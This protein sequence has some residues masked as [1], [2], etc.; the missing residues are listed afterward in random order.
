MVAAHGARPAGVVPR[1]GARR[2]PAR[3][4]RSGTAGTPAARTARACSTV[5]VAGVLAVLVAQLVAPGAVA[6]AGVPLALIGIVLGVPHGAVDHM[7]P[8]WTSGR[9][10]DRAALARVLTGYL[11]VAAAAATALLVLPTVTV[12]VFLVVSA[13]HFGTAEVAV[14]AE[15][16]G[17]PT[18]GP[19]QEVLLAAAHGAA[20]VVL[21]VALWPGESAAVL[22]RLAPALSVPAPP[23]LRAALLLV[24][25]GLVLAAV[26]HLLRL[27]RTGQTAEL[28]LV[29]ALFAVVPP[30]AAFGVYFAGWHALR[31]TGRLLGLPGRDGA[32]PS[33][34]RAVARLALHAAL[35]TAV[36]LAVVVV[37]VGGRAP[38]AAVGVALGVLV[39]LTFPH[40]RSVAL[41]DRWSRGARSRG[42]ASRGRS[43]TY[44]RRAG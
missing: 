17:R 8:F 13:V 6:A 34:G 31:H 38:D 5:G 22:G 33:A 26:V 41:L 25:A 36:T 43:V 24:L 35:P 20:V 9:R 32:V 14:A 30:L 42:S 12:L 44:G 2:Q 1:P 40:V 27:H 29:V 21:P 4:V 3:H 37:L 15:R 19:T 39:A 18:P 28:L 16:A 11:L 7:V 23:V 10:P